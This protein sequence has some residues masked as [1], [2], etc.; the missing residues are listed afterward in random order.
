MLLQEP[1]LHVWLYNQPTDMRKQLD[2]LAALA[3]TQMHCQASSGD[4]FV[5]INRKRTYM[6]ILYYSKG[7]YCLWCKRLEKGRFHSV[8]ED[9]NDKDKQ[10]LDWAQLQCLIDGINWQKYAK[11]SRYMR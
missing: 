3:Q 9:D 8:R 11:H 7:G 5:F 2:G 10:P 6:K 1:N 4:L